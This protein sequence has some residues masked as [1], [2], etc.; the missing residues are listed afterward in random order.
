MS[1]T[2]ESRR[3]RTL[4][5]VRMVLLLVASACLLLPF[6][7]DPGSVTVTGLEVLSLSSG[8]PPAL[9][10]V[11]VLLVCAAALTLVHRKRPSVLV[12]LGTL[13]TILLATGLV[14]QKQRALHVFL[15]G[16]DLPGHWLVLALLTGSLITVLADLL[17]RDVRNDLTGP[18]RD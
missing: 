7:G 8:P 17:Y 6:F 16:Q 12:L 2:G 14:V 1:P 18:A 15:P 11:V 10:P 4:T 5:T 13:L 3:A 9:V